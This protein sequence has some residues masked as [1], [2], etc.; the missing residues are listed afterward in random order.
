MS[1][2][3]DRFVSVESHR[4]ETTG[5][6]LRWSALALISAICGR[7]VYSKIIGPRGP[8]LF[9]NLFIIL[10]GS[11]SQG[12][13][14]A[15][16]A[17]KRTLIDLHVPFGADTI[18]PQRFIS[19]YSKVSISKIEDGLDPS[20][21]VALEN[22]DSLLNGRNDPRLKSFLCASYDCSQAFTQETIKRGNETARKLCLTFI[23]GG[24]PAH[25][26]AAFEQREWAEG[27]AARFL[28][29]NADEDYC[30]GPEPDQLIIDDFLRDL[31][32]LQSSISGKSVQIPWS[33]D[34]FDARK[35]LAKTIR[36]MP[37]IH[38]HAVGYW[39][40][41]PLSA[42]KIAMLFS[43][44]DGS[45]SV[46][47][48]HWN[49]AISWLDLLETGMADALSMTGGNPYSQIQAAILRWCR[50]TNRPVAEWEIR[51]RLV[52]LVTPSHLDAVVEA[53]ISSRQLLVVDGETRPNRRLIHPSLH[54]A[55][56][57]SQGITPMHKV[58]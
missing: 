45:F 1:S 7:S 18:T 12:K 5:I 56:M 40:K 20:V 14:Q 9:P 17:L 28:F 58:V 4:C 23:A 11:P 22:M 51:S 16:A 31:R 35:A 30:E 52:N 8:S 48:D 27:L 53:M 13:T 39:S 44:S 54:T 57:A 47:L 24:T 49:E 41:K 3:I 25:V 38:P 15:I 10:V 19:W 34:A 29:V 50:S 33:Q 37:P 32:N 2:L 46:T 43:I 42:A 6:Y 36:K 26:G 21:T 55:H